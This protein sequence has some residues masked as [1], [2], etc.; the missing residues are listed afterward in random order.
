MEMTVIKE[1]VYYTHRPLEARGMS[2]Y[3]GPHGETPIQD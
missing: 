1:E 3:A 2:Y